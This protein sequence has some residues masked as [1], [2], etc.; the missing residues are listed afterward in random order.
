[1]PSP[2]EERRNALMLPNTISGITLM[3]TQAGCNVLDCTTG[4]HG[5][6]QHPPDLV[7]AADARTSVCDLRVALLTARG[8]ST[9]DMDRNGWLTLAALRAMRAKK[10]RLGKERP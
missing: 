3:I 4:R 8:H 9:E 6:E 5:Y 10:Q 7:A 2:G 1:M